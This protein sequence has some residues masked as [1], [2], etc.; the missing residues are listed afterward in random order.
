MF[1]QKLMFVQKFEGKGIVGED[2]WES[3]FE[4]E[5]TTSAKALRPMYVL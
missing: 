2:F 1:T 5:V 3:A 4:A